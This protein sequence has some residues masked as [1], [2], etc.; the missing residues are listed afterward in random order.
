M[1]QPSYASVKNTEI[2]DSSDSL[3]A[4]WSNESDGLNSVSVAFDGF[5]CA[6][7]AVRRTA[8][9]NLAAFWADQA[10]FATRVR[11]DSIQHQTGLST[12]CTGFLPHSSHQINFSALANLSS[13]NLELTNIFCASPCSKLLLASWTLVSSSANC[14]SRICLAVLPSL[15]G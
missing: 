15:I 7:I 2:S 1:K 4:F 14:S 12:Y 11:L 13:K 5:P 6:A 8:F 3:T 10:P 9:G